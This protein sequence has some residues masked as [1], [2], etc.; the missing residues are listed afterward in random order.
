MVGPEDVA[1]GVLNAWK[2]S[3]TRAACPGGL[4]YGRVD[5]SAQAPYARLGVKASDLQRLSDKRLLR[6]FDVQIEVWGDTGPAG[7]L[8]QVR[9]A[10]E[11]VLGALT[12]PG[13]VKVVDAR[14]AETDL[15]LDEGFRNA[16]DVCLLTLGW[17]VLVE[18]K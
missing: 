8:A 11:T 15:A 14:P 7:Q 17:R 6:W 1:S 3:S 10:A 12:V 16:N 5:E 9:K 13:S 2:A 18:A 4:W